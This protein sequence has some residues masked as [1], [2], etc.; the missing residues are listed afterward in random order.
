MAQA[1]PFWQFPIQ[2]RQEHD[3]IQQTIA[4]EHRLSS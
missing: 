4:Y 1:T 2:A 3:E